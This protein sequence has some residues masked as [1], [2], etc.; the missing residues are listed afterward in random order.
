MQREQV[1]SRQALEPRASWSAGPYTVEYPKSLDLG[2]T[3]HAAPLSRYIA[4]R[5][6]PGGRAL[7]VFAGPG[8]LGLQL[9]AD[10]LVASID[11]TDIEIS[12][13]NCIE[14]TIECSKV[15]SKCRA[16]C[17][18]NLSAVPAGNTYD[19]IVG[20]PPW[21]FIHQ[22]IASG[23]SECDPGWQ[24][25]KRFWGEVSPLLSPGALV[26]LLEWKP[27][28]TNPSGSGR[29]NWDRRPRQPA[30]DFREMIEKAGLRCAE[31]SPISGSWSGLYAI[32]A[33]AP[34]WSRY[35]NITTTMGSPDDEQSN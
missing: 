11:F 20:N 26:I 13:I 24:L 3:E 2:G 12:A 14:R 9:L 23:E 21:S 28:E 19:L 6:L 1:M 4:Q 34:G 32:V 5:L 18:D 27:F 35:S 15:S 8:F 33:Q 25:H 17:G 10:G 30:D 22:D 31:M 7:E 16:F 29:E